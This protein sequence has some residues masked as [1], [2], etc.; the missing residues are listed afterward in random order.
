MGLRNRLGTTAAAALGTVLVLTSCTSGASKPG[1][2]PASGTSSAPSSSGSTTAGPSVTDPSTASAT[3][4]ASS[5]PVGTVWTVP[6]A[7]DAFNVASDAYSEVRDSDPLTASSTFSS[8]ITKYTHISTACA[9][10][11]SFLRGGNW[12]AKAAPLAAEVANVLD[13]SC[14]DYQRASQATTPAELNSL[15]KLSA[16]Y[17]NRYNAAL[18]ALY[19]EIGL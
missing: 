14:V 2:T 5:G 12:P 8:A 13:E 1:S 6:Q 11:V 3:P 18:V 17:Q 19:P 7:R 10:F 4:S 9:Q 16:D 15:P